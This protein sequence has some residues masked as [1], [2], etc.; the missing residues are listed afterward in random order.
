MFE[1]TIELFGDYYRC[2]DA[3]A[4]PGFNGNLGSEVRE[5][6]QQLNYIIN[7]VRDLEQVANKAFARHEK[8]FAKH[9]SKLD[10][11]NLDFECTPLP[12]EVNI[13]KDEF[14]KNKNAAFEMKLLTETYYYI[15]GRIRM[16]F[17]NPNAPLPGLTSFECEGTRNVR[18]K[19]LEHAEGKDSQV[20]IQ[21]FGY[22]AAHGPV[23][24]SIRYSG[25][26]QIFPDQG[27]HK[28]AEEFRD[29]LE[30]LLQVELSKHR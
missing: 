30:S 16:I 9:V 20:S 17:R 8:A 13:T 25:Q 28:N 24:K 29:N 18:N 19:L 15:A 27:L 5:R 21:S 2:I 14:N 4:V 23:L 11:L 7:K 22:G 10:R 3:A 12:A 6:L 1:S 26:E